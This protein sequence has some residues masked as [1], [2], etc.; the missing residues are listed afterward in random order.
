MSFPPAD[1]FSS[2]DSSRYILKALFSIFSLKGGKFLV[3][4][5]FWEKYAVKAYILAPPL[6]LFCPPQKL[7]SGGGEKRVERGKNQKI[8][9]AS[10]EIQARFAC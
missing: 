4:L 9:R 10:R 3:I 8:F 1:I 5:V 7:P 6:N 2:F